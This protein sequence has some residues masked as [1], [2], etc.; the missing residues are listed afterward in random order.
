MIVLIWE[1]Q[2]V[3]VGAA[4]LQVMVCPLCICS[5]CQH[6]VCSQLLLLRQVACITV[7]WRG[8]LAQQC[9]HHLATCCLH[10]GL[11]LRAGLLVP[12]HQ[13]REPCH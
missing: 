13:A 9:F 6:G 12:G 4:V 1:R 11:P 10:C 8:R 3:S 7:W 5:C 2:C